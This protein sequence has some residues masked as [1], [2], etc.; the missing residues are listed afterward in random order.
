MNI[1][2]GIG[3]P[4][5][6][7]LAPPSKS[8]AHRSIICAAL[9]EESTVRNIAL[10]EDIKATLS[11]LES[12]GAR[13]KI[14]ENAVTVGGLELKNI[15]DNAQLFAN[16]SGSTLRFLIPLLLCGKTVKISGKESL[17]S[18][19]LNIYTDIFDSMGIQY[20][21]NENSLT[22][23]GKFKGNEV[24]L[25]GNVSSQFITG[26]CLLFA[27]NGGGKITVTEK[28]E[29]K[30]YIDI[31]LDV[32]RDFG[33][34][35]CFEDNVI[36]IFEGSFKSR[37]YTVEGDCSNA[38]Y[39]EAFNLLGGDIRLFGVPESTKQGDIVYKKM[40]AELK[41][42]K[43]HFDLSDCPDLAPVMFSI[44]AYLGDITFSG[45]RRL[46][47]KESD[48]VSAM[49]NELS[50]F[51]IKSEIKENELRILGGRINAPKEVLF[52]HNDHRIVMALSLLL[53]KFGG[54]I[55]NAEAVSKS[56]PDYFN[57][58]KKLGLDIYEA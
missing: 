37:E 11:C 6:T 46:K 36:E 53:A 38:A 7:I 26:F 34:K 35:S 21:L 14:K 16:E 55:E 10:S 33:I 17:F 12:L 15:P 2:F 57:K 24:S 58:L 40:F 3:M 19:P 20:A 56:F 18:R 4:Q 28:I 31:T 9:S 45:T 41:A 25:K 50:K 32:L 22:L 27:A 51:G 49:C 42:G 39:I 44:A 8:V 48:R 1:K 5:G 29:S 43:N 52:S 23:N 13:V 30:P 47:I 54:Q